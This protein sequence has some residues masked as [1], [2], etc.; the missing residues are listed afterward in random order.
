M[1]K[2]PNTLA[3]DTTSFKALMAEYKELLTFSDVASWDKRAAIEVENLV[4]TVHDVDKKRTGASN[5]LGEI[6]KEHEGKGFFQRMFDSKD[7]EK[8]LVQLVENYN[9]Y[10]SWLEDM[11]SQ[12]Q[13][14]IDFTPNSPEEKKSL[15]KE[16]KER[17][18]E[19]QLEKREVAAAMK[20]IR[21]DARKQSAVAGTSKSMFGTTYN[22]SLAAAQRRGIRYQKESALRPQEDAKTA[23]ER[24]LI[25][26]DRDISWAERFS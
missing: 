14:A 20:A 12:L 16:L 2:D 19:L 22:S 13:E 3:Y 7:Q 24:Q 8:T 5:K 18:K 10:I 21:T 11:A 25:Q 9:K 26:V 6:R 15:L 1:T 17:K 4:R 23:I